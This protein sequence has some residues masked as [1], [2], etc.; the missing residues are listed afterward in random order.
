MLVIVMRVV[1]ILA[2]ND[3]SDHI[4]DSSDNSEYIGDINESSDDHIGDHIGD[5][6]SDD[7]L[8]ILVIMM[9]VIVVLILVIVVVI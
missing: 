1:I 3:S 7:I 4:C 6:V 2:I 5:S 8:I 9:V